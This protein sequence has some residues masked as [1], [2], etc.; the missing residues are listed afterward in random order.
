M[1]KLLAI[2]LALMLLTASTAL[3]E[4]ASIIQL[5]N[6]QVTNSVDGAEQ[7]IRLEGLDATLAI[8]APEGVG[9]VQLDVSNGSEALLGAVMQFVDDQV[10]LAVDGVDRPLASP[11]NVGGMSLDS[12][13]PTT[14]IAEMFANASALSDV[15]MPVFKGATIPKVPLFDIVDMLGMF[16]ITLPKE[17]D[18]N[19]VTTASFS[20]PYEVINQLLAYLPYMIPEENKA[21]L[22]PLLDQLN[23]LAQQGGGFGLEGKLSDDGQTAEMLIDLLPVV[24]GAPAADPAAGLYFKSTENYDTLQILVYQEGQGIPV[25]VIELESNPD[26]AT[27]YVTANLAGQVNLSF[28][29]RPSDEIDGAQVAALEVEGNG[30]TIAASLTYGEVDG[31]EFVDFA[32]DAAG[33]AAISFHLDETPDGNGGKTGALD[34]RFENG[35]QIVAVT[36]DVAEFSGDVTFRAVQNAENAYNAQT[37]TAEEQQEFAAAL[38]AA[39]A[40]LINYMNSLGA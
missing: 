8:G 17:T 23:A 33:Q 7:V 27:L 1:K 3:A 22:Q 9:T 32:V 13:D 39:L 24:D 20:V 16:G 34:V 18:A 2:L 11:I 6:I 26:E 38:N 37:I 12:Q 4:S 10:L 28:G 29:L 15:K 31:T 30:Q 14:A 19:G 36:A 5:N 40:P 25:A 21:Q 35:N